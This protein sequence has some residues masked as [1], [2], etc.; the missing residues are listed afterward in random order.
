MIAHFVYWTTYWPGTFSS[1]RKLELSKRHICM[2]FRFHHQRVRLFYY[3]M[4][5]AA[6]GIIT[7]CARINELVRAYHGENYVNDM[8]KVA[9]DPFFD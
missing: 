8:W 2:P 7:K 1:R 6:A 9:V 3:F 5:A 4:A